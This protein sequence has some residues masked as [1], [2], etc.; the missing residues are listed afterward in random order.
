[1]CFLLLS[2]QI[3]AAEDFG[4][5]IGEI[6]ART[7]GDETML[8]DRS[9]HGRSAS[10]GAGVGDDLAAEDAALCSFL[11]VRIA[12][13]QGEGV[14]HESRCQGDGEDRQHAASYVTPRIEQA[15]PD[16]EHDLTSLVL[17][18]IPELLILPNHAILVANLVRGES[19]MV[20]S[21][22]KIQNNFGHYLELAVNEEIIITRNGLPVARLLGMN[23]AISFLSD[24]LVGLIPFDASEER[25]RDERLQKQ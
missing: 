8:P 11:E 9:L 21:S 2:V 12:S 4:I 23:S 19:T 17:L 22:S 24:Q 14:G 5:E 1:M 16:E 20:I 25:L 6:T 10:E 15:E 7:L 3:S 18:A 13:A